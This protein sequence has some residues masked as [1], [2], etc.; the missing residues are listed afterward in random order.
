Q[1]LPGG[2]E[3][4]LAAGVTRSGRVLA[5]LAGPQTVRLLDF[6]LRAGPAPL[7]GP[8]GGLMGLAFASDGSDLLGLGNDTTDLRRWD[9]STGKARPAPLRLGGAD[10][11]AIAW[12]DK[13]LP[14]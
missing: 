6:P 10:L 2:Q 5:V 14:A 13:G 4:L 1:V 9:G 8:D 12:T 7:A 3:T 11:G